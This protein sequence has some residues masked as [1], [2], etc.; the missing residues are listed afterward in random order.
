[1]GWRK[2][3]CRHFQDCLCGARPACRGRQ[4]PA[5]APPGRHA[6]VRCSNRPTPAAPQAT[7]NIFS[8]ST[9]DEWKAELTA[10]LDADGDGDLELEE[11]KTFIQADGVLSANKAVRNAVAKAER[12]LARGAKQSDVLAALAP[13]RR[14]LEQSARREDAEAGLSNDDVNARSMLAR[15]LS[16]MDGWK[17]PAGIKVRPLSSPEDGELTAITYLSGV[18]II[19]LFTALMGPLIAQL[20]DFG[21]EPVR[22]LRAFP[23]DWRC[24]PSKLEERD[25]YFS[26]LMD[27][28]EQLVRNAGEK[29]VLVAHSMG[30]RVTHYF[31]H[32][33]A[34]SEPGRARGGAAWLDANVHS[35]VPIGGPFLGACS[36]TMQYLQP[37]NVAGLV[38]A[39]LSTTDGHAML[40]SWGSMPFVFGSDLALRTQPASHL[41]WVRREGVL[42]VEIL[43][44]DLGGVPGITEGVEPYVQLALCGHDPADPDATQRLQSDKQEGCQAE[45]NELFQFCWDHQPET[46]AGMWLKLTVKDEREMAPDKT[47]ASVTLE[48][49][50]TGG[51][52]EVRCPPRKPAGARHRGAPP[53]CCH[54]QRMKAPRPTTSAHRSP[55]RRVFAPA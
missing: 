39:V 19:K 16:L 42:H 54:S 3:V 25:G 26:C 41:S 43:S 15:H 48:L 24:P 30:C 32:W 38:P 50:S 14:I 11:L 29:C 13:V 37:G 49:S 2:I 33:V 5:P 46:L 9:S 18:P 45:F 34:T 44:L 7:K 55:P 36:G 31:T 51:V 8:I 4:E 23:Y 35:L 53:L 52:A 28:I 21:Y 22:M 17:D 27:G 20:Q 47:L 10:L 40:R 6:S 1:L 12:E